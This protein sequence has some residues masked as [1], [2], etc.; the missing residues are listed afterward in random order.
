MSGSIPFCASSRIWSSRRE[1]K[2]LEK[3]Q[4]SLMSPS[5]QIY[6]DF[7]RITRGLLWRRMFEFGTSLKRPR[8]HVK[9]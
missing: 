6:N 9:G 1:G 4:L 8:K 5:S 2:L 3:R 7:P